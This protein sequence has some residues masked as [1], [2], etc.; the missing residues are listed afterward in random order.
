MKNKFIESIM[1]SM[2]WFIL[3]MWVNYSIIDAPILLGR[4]KTLNYILKYTSMYSL[5]IVF[6]HLN[7]KKCNEQGLHIAV[8]YA[9]V[10]WQ[11][12][13]NFTFSSIIK[14]LDSR[15]SWFKYNTLYNF[16][17]LNQSHWFSVVN[18]ESYLRMIRLEYTILS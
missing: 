13:L 12:V 9:T 8:R 10:R 11:I 3:F 16:A 6:K 4:H 17:F 2:T 7:V 18:N 15:L 5:E 14:Q 1:L